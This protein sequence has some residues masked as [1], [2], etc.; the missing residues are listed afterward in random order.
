M[1]GH[2]VEEA[3]EALW[4]CDEQKEHDINALRKQCE[5]EI[6][7]ELLAELERDDL[8][9]KD[10]DMFTL[11]NDGKTRASGV[12]RRHRLAERLFTDILHVPHSELDKEA[13][14]FEHVLASQVEESICTLLGH[15]KE[16]PHGAVIPPG[17]CCR[18]A[19]D[20]IDNV[21][22]PLNKLEPGH[23]AKIAYIST[24]DHSRFHKLFSFG[25][26]PGM[27]ITLHQKKPTYV[28]HC[29]QT[30]LAFEES[31]ARNIF[32]WRDR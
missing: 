31:F 20:V 2:D 24:K 3:L 21:V 10:G 11:T 22:I 4:V 18:E 12:V 28:I 9:V 30:E 17:S 29:E 13:C 32:V 6:T 5:I 25:L 15:P 8:I 23:K 26:T 14:K 7:D 27:T 1:N 16:C 19:R